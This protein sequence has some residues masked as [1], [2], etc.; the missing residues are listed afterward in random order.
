MQ[1][2]SSLRVTGQNPS[3]EK[4][5]L[6]N[7][8]MRD[9]AS[10][11]EANSVVTG[12]LAF[13]LYDGR[14]S[15]SDELVGINP[16]EIRNIKGARIRTPMSKIPTECL[17]HEGQMKVGLSSL[18]TSFCFDTNLFNACAQNDLGVLAN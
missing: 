12:R 16:R 9:E 1:N 17:S 18:I 3:Q 2:A 14:T 10:S 6:F 15:N 13:D 4:V 5:R 8:M 7:S 11:A